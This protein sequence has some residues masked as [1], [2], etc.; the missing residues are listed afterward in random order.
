[1]IPNFIMG[2]PGD[3]YKG[4]VEWVQEFVDIMPAV[5]VNCLA[6]HFGNERGDLDL[7]EETFGDRDQNT[8]TK[9][10]LADDDVAAGLAAVQDIYAITEG[11]W[12][13][14]VAYPSEQVTV[15]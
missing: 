10:W 4:T 11:Y 13:D 3:D 15:R 2:I 6:A 9:S 5:N 7:P 8:V 1:M 14:R 12:R